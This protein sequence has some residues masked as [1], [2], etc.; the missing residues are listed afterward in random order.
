MSRSYK[1]LPVQEFTHGVYKLVPIRDQDKYAIMV[2]RNDQIDILRQKELLTAQAQESYF[3]NV[4]DKLFEAEK[5][6]ELIFSFFEGDSLIGYGG[7]VHIDWVSR[8]GEISFITETRRTINKNQFTSDWKNYLNVLKTIAKDYLVFFK[9]YTYA[10]DVR[11]E[12]FKALTESGFVQEARL[13]KHIF[14]KDN[15]EDVLIHSLFLSD[16]SLRR[17]ESSDL[18]LYFDWAN[19][20]DVRQNSFNQELIPLEIHAS[21]FNTKIKS[22]HSVMFIALMDGSH[23]GQI[24]FDE[25]EPDIFE[26]DFSIASDFRG[27]AIGNKLLSAGCTRLV[28]ERPYCKRIIGTVK[29][30]NNASIRSFINS[31]FIRSSEVQKNGIETYILDTP[32]NL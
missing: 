26:I 22:K 28:Q 14:I 24:R 16:I 15:L 12:L 10:Y 11:P 25:I 20:R 1:C 2:W 6:T 9:I 21:W 31:G 29:G 7:L 5:P 8:C 18:M 17:A 4:V 19:D 30:S 13:K 27:M 32:S 3:R 23:I